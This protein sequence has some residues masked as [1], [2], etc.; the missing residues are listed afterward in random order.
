MDVRVE[1]ET[2]PTGFKV[3]LKP[4]QQDSSLPE[5]LT[6]TYQGLRHVSNSAWIFGKVG[7]ARA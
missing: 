4:Q 2:Q 5:G 1:L 7:V 6:C 3:V